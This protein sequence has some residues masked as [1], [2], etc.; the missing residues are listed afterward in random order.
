MTLQQCLSRIYSGKGTAEADKYYREHFMTEEERQIGKP[1]YEMN[2][3]EN[4]L[5]DVLTANNQAGNERGYNCP[6]CLNRGYSWV[7]DGLYKSMRDCSCMS[8]RATIRRMKESGMGNLLDLYSFEKYKRDEEWQK[9]V[10]SKAKTFVG[11]KDKNFF[12]IGGAVGSGKT[13]ICTAMVKELLRQGKS[14]RYMLWMSESEELKQC[15]RDLDLYQPK[16]REIKQAE[17]LYIDDLFKAGATKA[18]IRLA[19]E[20]INYRYNKARSDKS[21]RYI[22]IISCEYDLGEIIKLDEALGS[23]IFEMTKPNYTLYI[24]DDGKRNYRMK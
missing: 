10:Y 9:A 23:R 20:I 7:K 11:D 24:E 22:T 12:Y 6:K 16:I 4:V 15:V 5:Y 21:K 2:D 13:F 19:F 17:V 8:I 3:D 1:I 18:D 14:A